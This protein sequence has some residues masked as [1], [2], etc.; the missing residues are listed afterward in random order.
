MTMKNTRWIRHA[1]G[2]VLLLGVS[3]LT[4]CEAT[5][6]AAGVVSV[7][8][9]SAAICAGHCHSI[10]LQ[11]SA[12]AIMASNVG[13]VCQRPGTPPQSPTAAGETGTPIGGMTALLMQ[14]AADE[15]RRRQAYSS[16]SHR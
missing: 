3:S 12:V 15:A 11:L 14:Q 13:C 5:V 6:G 10:G 1:L 16:P 2:V 4:G 9:N 8:P 7:P